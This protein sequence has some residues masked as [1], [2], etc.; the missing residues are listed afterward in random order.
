MGTFAV[1]AL[2]IA[3]LLSM[4]PHHG[5]WSLLQN[6]TWAPS[7]ISAAESG[8]SIVLGSATLDLTMLD[9]A[10]LA[11]DVN[12]PIDVA[13]SRVVI[14]VPAGIP[15]TIES[16]LAAAVL[17]VNGQEVTEDNVGGG[18]STTQVNPG[19]TGHGIIISLG[20]AA[21]DVTVTPLAGQ[22]SPARSIPHPPLTR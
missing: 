1:I 16:N 8:R 21:A 20:G 3:G 7:S 22:S 15:V 2:V 14:K 11:Q 6:Q 9:D 13:A 12:V 4:V 19:A 18:K 5:Q 17:R 10:A